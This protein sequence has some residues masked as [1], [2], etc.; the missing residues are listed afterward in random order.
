MMAARKNQNSLSRRQL[1]RDHRGD[2]TMSIVLTERA[3]FSLAERADERKVS[4]AGTIGAEIMARSN[5]QE[6]AAGRFCKW[7]C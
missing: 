1:N 3:L 5:L 4:A 6:M 7:N 2:C